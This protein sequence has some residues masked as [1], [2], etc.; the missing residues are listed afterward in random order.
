MQSVEPKHQ[1]SCLT[2]AL[3]QYTSAVRNM[4]HTVML[5]SLLRDVTLDEESAMADAKDLYECYLMLKSIRNTVESGLMPLDDWKT[6]SLH[7]TKETQNSEIT[8]PEAIFYLH[9][10]GLYSVL[11][12]LTKK[13]QSLTK[14][15][16]DIIGLAN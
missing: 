16:K 4:E 7:F 2:M 9:L 14:R 1:K 11:N 13:S 10:K 12:N 3:A 5:P 6:K 15:Y 8:D